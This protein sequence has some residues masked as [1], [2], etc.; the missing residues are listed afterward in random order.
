M[1]PE[2]GA[3]SSMKGEIAV[4]SPTAV[5]V[6]ADMYAGLIRALPYE[7]ANSNTGRI[8]SA[9]RSLIPRPRHAL[10]DTNARA[11]PPRL[12]YI[13]T[14]VQFAVK[15]PYTLDVGNSNCEICSRR[16]REP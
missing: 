9:G 12:L 4:H 7:G 6:V 14:A 15:Q 3:M 1:L 10:A 11:S 2:V 5:T 16:T 8:C 13:G